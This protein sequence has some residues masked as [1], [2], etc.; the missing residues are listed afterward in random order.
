M[1]A[2]FGVGDVTLGG[3]CSGGSHAVQAAFAGVPV[4]RVL[5]VNPL[6]FYWQPGEVDVDEVQ[7]WEVVHKPVAYLKLA[8]SAAAWRR[9]LFG[10][11]SLWR[12]AQIYLTRPLMAGQAWVK[13]IA[14]AMHIRMKHDL[15]WD[16]KDLKERGVRVVFVFSDGD[17]GLS[18]LQLQSG[19]S[20]QQL[21]EDY[22]LRMIDDADH[23]FTRSRPRV[24]LA[25][26]LSEELY[27]FNQTSAQRA[28]GAARAAAP[29]QEGIRP[30]P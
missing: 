2:K 27:A 23:E 29:L 9:L 22:C 11:L 15:W 30:T 12:I 20:R 1:R 10:D 4:D 5:M 14:R 19:L 25:K 6:I 28:L 17:A 21:Q 18:L 26:V 8:F 13:Q 24:E 7:P 3:I 16:L